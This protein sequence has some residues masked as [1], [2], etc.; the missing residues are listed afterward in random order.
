MKMKTC[1]IVFYVDLRRVVDFNYGHFANFA[2]AEM[3]FKPHWRPSTIVSIDKEYIYIIGLRYMT[4]GYTPICSRENTRR[5]I[6]V[7]QF[8]KY[9]L[10]AHVTAN[11]PEQSFDL[12]PQLN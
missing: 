10:K 3:T 11:I 12:V 9:E 4:S 5:P 7:V 6:Y 2:N 1:F 8:V